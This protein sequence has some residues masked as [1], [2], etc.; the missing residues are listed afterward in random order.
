MPPVS[1][2]SSPI[3]SYIVHAREGGDG[4][5]KQTMQTSDAMCSARVTVKPDAW[6]EFCVSACSIA[7]E[8]PPSRPSMPVLTRKR[9]RH[10]HKGGRRSKS[11]RGS[12]KERDGGGKS[13]S[14]DHDGR[15]RRRGR[16]RH[17]SVAS[18]DD[19]EGESS[20]GDAS[21]AS[22][23]EERSG[24]GGGGGGGR[25][26]GGGYAS[27][28][29]G[30][31]GPD[32]QP[33]DNAAAD[34][35]IALGAGGAARFKELKASLASLE[36]A[37]H[38]ALGHEP[39]DAE[40]AASPRYRQMAVEYA[41]LRERRDEH[42]ARVAEKR[43]ALRDWQEVLMNLGFDVRAR[44]AELELLKSRWH[45]EFSGKHGGRT[46]TLH[47]KLNS[48][49][50][51]LL[52][53]A[54]VKEKVAVEVLQRALDRVTSFGHCTGLV[55]HL[56]RVSTEMHASS[57]ALMRRLA[58]QGA[59][60]G[61]M[62]IHKLLDDFVAHDS[63]EIGALGVDDFTRLARH[64]L[65]DEALGLG[66]GEDSGDAEEAA[67]SGQTV[68]ALNA[69]RSLRMH[70]RADVD[71]DGLV[72]FNEWVK[73]MQPYLT[74]N[75]VTT[76]SN[77]FKQRKG[78]RSQQQRGVTP[79]NDLLGRAAVHLAESFKRPK[80]KKR[81]ADGARALT[82]AGEDAALTM[83]QDDSAE[84]AAAAAAAAAAAE[85]KARG[86]GGSDPNEAYRA[87]YQQAAAPAA[88][89]GETRSGSM[90]GSVVILTPQEQAAAAESASSSS[91]AHAQRQGPGGGGA[92]S[93]ET[94][95]RALSLG[96]EPNRTFSYQPQRS[97]SHHPVLGSWLGAGGSEDEGYGEGAEEEE[98]D[99]GVTLRTLARQGA[100]R[101]K[102]EADERLR[103]KLEREEKAKRR[104]IERKAARELSQGYL[105]TLRARVEATVSAGY[106]DHTKALTPRA[107]K[108]LCRQM[109][110]FD[111]SG[112]GTL[113]LDDFFGLCA[114]IAESAG[115]EEPLNQMQL[116]GLFTQA[117]VTGAHR[118]C[119]SQ[120]AWA[121]GQLAT[122]VSEQVRALERRRM[123]AEAARQEAYKAEQ[124]AMDAERERKEALKR[125]FSVVTLPPDAGPPQDDAPLALMPP[126]GMDDK[127]HPA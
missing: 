39:S 1:I 97:A 79:T 121:R 102:A 48:R 17:K 63:Q 81:H 16:R 119:A 38:D 53:E 34:L 45:M 21:D 94:G 89:S 70:S 88:Q 117:D 35:T 2:G 15:R 54:I 72:D 55:D 62:R 27:A 112:A 99:G 32:S 107:L 91:S 86:G 19:S 68:E 105:G 113:G 29:A 12:S 98:E 82:L 110:R 52:H 111:A 33:K 77:S 46:A 13:D 30:G 56:E 14:E 10:S 73:F 7:G 75:R 20:D 83:P 42:M 100:E 109:H 4:D 5:F 87:L 18:G 120:W 28:A 40:L 90:K 31:S 61:V 49:K 96:L 58:K 115:L 69:Q 23:A 125:S 59:K 24:G 25:G 108:Q 22:D 26:R 122:M 92:A 76:A 47:E 8:G 80:K 104:E 41:A 127:L 103:V 3:F 93:I 106:E 123:D 44:L 78:D 116:V 64:E 51:V 57:D 50:Y 101:K 60:D 37:K 66:W 118:I 124:A 126:R 114:R 71:G 43:A 11:G 95:M 74:N 9:I 84:E 65:G 67:A 36:K 85:G 6:L